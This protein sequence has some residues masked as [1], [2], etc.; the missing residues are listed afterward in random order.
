MTEK[1][2]VLIFQ[3]QAGSPVRMSVSNVRDDVTDLEVRTA[4]ETIIG[5]NIFDSTGGDLTTI[6]GAEIVTRNVQ[7]LDVK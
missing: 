4:M 6:S 2:L 3:N 7:E 5:K 1:T